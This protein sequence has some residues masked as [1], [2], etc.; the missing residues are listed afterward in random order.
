MK[1][2]DF[3]TAAAKLPIGTLADVTGGGGLVMSLRIRTTRASAAAA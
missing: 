1:A 2:A 3:L